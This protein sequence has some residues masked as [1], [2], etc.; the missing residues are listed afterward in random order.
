MDTTEWIRGRTVSQVFADI[1]RFLLSAEYGLDR[2]KE[3]ADNLLLLMG[4]DLNKEDLTYAVM[5][6]ALATEALAHE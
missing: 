4:Q 6:M 5:M 1:K 3:E 2:V